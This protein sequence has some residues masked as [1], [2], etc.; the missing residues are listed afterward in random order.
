VRSVT[1]FLHFQVF[2]PHYY[3][4]SS[5]TRKFPPLLK[6]IL[7]FRKNS[8]VNLSVEENPEENLLF[9]DKLPRRAIT[10]QI[11]KVKWNYILL[12]GAT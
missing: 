11:S 6:L 1:S 9:A 4:N 12:N 7:P 5:I 8:S 3:K 2:F 10:A